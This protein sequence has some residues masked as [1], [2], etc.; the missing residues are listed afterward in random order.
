ME[1]RSVRVTQAGEAE[2]VLTGRR[3]LIGRE[4]MPGV[5]GERCVTLQSRRASSHGSG[6]CTRTAPGS[7]RRG[8]ASSPRVP[9]M[10]PGTWLALRCPLNNGLNIY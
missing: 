4:V 6:A 10:L 2:L 7:L 5:T 1:R 3:G 8:P 9:G